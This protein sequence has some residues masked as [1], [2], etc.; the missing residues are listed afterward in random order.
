MNTVTKQKI[1]NN[2]QRLLEMSKDRNDPPLN[3]SENE[4]DLW[5]THFAEIPEMD[6]DDF[7]DVE[8]ASGGGY[9]Y[10]RRY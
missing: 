9:E 7:Y 10:I 3:C 4:N 8:Y 1:R 5:I 6:V 2:L